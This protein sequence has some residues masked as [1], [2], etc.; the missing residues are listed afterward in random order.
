[1]NDKIDMPEE[2]PKKPAVSE[3][4]KKLLWEIYD[5][6]EV[7]ATVTIVVMLGFSFLGRLNIVEGQSMDHTLAE[8]QYLF[9]SDLFYEP[10]VGD[11][12]VVHDVT[13]DPYGDPIVK[14]V[15]A[16]GG[17]S[18]EID[19][20]TWTLK[21][22]GK[23]VEEPYRFL[24]PNYSTLRAEYNMSIDGIFH[25]IVPENEIFVMGDNRNASGDSR[26]VE[27]G[28]IDKRC[29]VGKAYLRLFPIDEFGLLE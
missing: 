15:I 12:V 27:I 2:Q 9:I 11:I 8:G 20:N 18:V 4:T 10:A 26:Q 1:M 6:L 5:L 29:V 28:T 24:D 17:Q 16:T 19:F 14:R 22:D 3:K 21:V 13:A 25:V 7:V 23:V